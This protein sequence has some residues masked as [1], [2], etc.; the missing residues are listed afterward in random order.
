VVAPG[1]HNLT[2][3]LEPGERAAFVIYEEETE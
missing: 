1:S 3:H 2:M